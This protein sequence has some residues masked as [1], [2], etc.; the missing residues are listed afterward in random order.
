MRTAGPCPVQKGSEQVIDVVQPDIDAG[1]V[2]QAGV[3]GS[4]EF[5]APGDGLRRTAAYADDS[6][7]APHQGLQVHFCDGSIPEAGQDQAS[8]LPEMF[9]GLEC[10]STKADGI[11][12]DVE[13]AALAMPAE[14]R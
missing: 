11:D 8:Q 2:L 13:S 3:S 14:G 12:D 10:W 4:K 7:R 9:R 5:D 6:R 1:H